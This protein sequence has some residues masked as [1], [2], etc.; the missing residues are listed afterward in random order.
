MINFY[1][2][3]SKIYSEYRQVVDKIL[4]G[5][6]A[7][8]NHRSPEFEDMYSYSVEVLKEKLEIP[9]KNHL[10]FLSSATECWET[11]C[12][13][14]R[15]LK[16]LFIVSGAFSNK[17]YNQ[18]IN[19]F[20]SCQAI[21]LSEYSSLEE[22]LPEE[23]F[24]LICYVHN[25]TSNGYQLTIEDQQL[26]RSKFP[27]ALIAVDATSSLGGVK[28]DYKHSDILFSS[29]QKCLGL[30][31]GLAIA[32]LSPKMV[33]E[34]ESLK[35]SHHY[36]HLKNILD[37][38]KKNQTTHTPNTTAII[39]MGLLYKNRFPVTEVAIETAQKSTLIYGFLSKNEDYRLFINERK[40][41][42]DTVFCLQN[43]KV[44]NLLD[45]A[46]KEGFLLGKGY[47]NLKEDW[48]RIA[49]FPAHT[50][51]EIRELL[52]FLERCK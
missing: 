21:S 22:I 9:L 50:M 45:K 48:F 28:I 43:N 10:I 38:S 37:N 12:Q 11:V 36:N 5:D 20:K 35:K 27:E 6:L 51:A 25:E 14:F 42:S 13:S 3:P 8:F 23:S 31:P 4:S 17:W 29:V 44:G 32:I 7:S 1:P 2:G 46:K 47:G 40:Y 39:S 33:E 15:H 30:P 18:G 49:N 34:I 16:C 41:Q 26:L 24:D 19:N 52:T